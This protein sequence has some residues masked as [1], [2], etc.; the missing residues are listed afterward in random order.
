MKFRRTWKEEDFDV[1]CTTSG[2]EQRR[3]RN[4]CCY[5]LYNITPQAAHFGE[6]WTSAQRE[7]DFQAGADILW[8]ASGCHHEEQDFSFHCMGARQKWFW[9]EHSIALMICVW[10]MTRYIYP[11]VGKQEQKHENGLNRM[12]TIIKDTMTDQIPPLPS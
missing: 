6:T 2:M 4:Q 12:K 9:T 1:I 7:R 8:A 11:R 3:A 5:Y 10:G